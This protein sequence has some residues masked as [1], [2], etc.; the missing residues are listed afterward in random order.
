M[1]FEL[2]TAPGTLALSR[3]RPGAAGGAVYF[4]SL[5]CA[6]NLVDSEAALGL[7]GRDGWH[8]S[9]SP[10]DADVLVVNTCGFLD[11]A[12]EESVE[13]ILELAALKGTGRPRILAVLGCLVARAAAELQESIPE[14][15]LWLPAGEHGRL[16]EALAERWDH[17][18]ADETRRATDRSGSGR[19][20]IGAFAGF[21]ARVLLTPAHT[22][23]LKISEGC[24]N[25]CTFCS[26]PLMR[27]LQRSR[28]LEEVVEEA[29]QLVARGV[30][31]LHLV[32]QDL[33]HYGFDLVP[34]YDL[35]DL[36]RAL[37][38]VRDLEWIRLLYA[39]P[40]HLTPRLLHGLFEVP[41]VA[42]YLDMPIQ[43]ASAPLLK[44]MHRS[45]TPERVRDQIEWLR[46]NVEGIALRS[47]VIVG[48][49]GETDRDFEVLVRFLAEARYDRLGIFTYSRE[50]GTPAYDYRPR[51]RASTAMRRMQ[52]LT[53]LQM[54]VAGERAAARVGTRVR[55]LVDAPVDDPESPIA[56]GTVARARSE[57]EALDIDGCIY[58]EAGERSLEDLAPG[59]FLDVEILAAD[60]HDLRARPVTSANSF[61]HNRLS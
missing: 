49:P 52:I 12:R 13:R 19:A 35:L 33:T 26:I 42:R 43:H 44:A 16:P 2:P 8:R 22:A 38:E 10:Q 55:V 57:A 61:P 51:P 36:V 29:T 4:D 40:A 14:V 3:S 48:F 30:R 6:K 37:S 60:V 9:D 7:L 50:P 15:D 24:S 46:R 20:P 47:T 21:G 41:K 34:R 54:H 25:A 45:H 59:R 11:A 17:L 31:E 27:G 28:P 5:G 23:Y 32:A 39:H 53:E 18:P 58:V 1:S 56:A